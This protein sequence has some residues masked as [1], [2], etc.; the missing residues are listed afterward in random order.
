MEKVIKA[1]YTG[2]LR[3]YNK[4]ESTKNIDNKTRLL[5]IISSIID[6]TIQDDLYL[7]QDKH[8]FYTFS[9][10]YKIRVEV[11]SVEIENLLKE[12]Q[13]NNITLYKAI[14]NKDALIDDS[15]DE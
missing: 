4:V 15:S 12:L 9:S 13:K 1:N 8:K 6:R 14:S 7:I 2:L 10:N 5:R 3:A 11:S